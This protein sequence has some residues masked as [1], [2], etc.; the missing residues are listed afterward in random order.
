MNSCLYECEVF[1]RRLRPKSHEF[2]YRVFYFYLDLGELDE[3]ARRLKFFRVNSPAA[4]SLRDGDHFQYAADGSG[5]PAPQDQAPRPMA[6]NVREFLRRAGA[7]LE[8]GGAIRMLCF[9][10]TFGYVFNPITIYWC[11]RADGAPHAA[12][13]E[14][15]NTFHELKPYLVPCA[16]GKGV[17][18]FEVRV[19]KE[20]YVSPFSPLDLEFHFRFH[21]PDGRLRVFIDDYDAAGKVLVS[22]LTGRRA[23]LSDARLAWLTLKYPL[24]TLRVIGLIHWQALKLWLKR[25][26][27]FLKEARPSDQRGV[28]RPHASLKKKP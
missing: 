4:Y 14:V 1:H 7:P 8:D 25:M 10:R 24:L 13:V 22:T 15:G 6:D 19:P 20:Y 12:V 26:P 17:A 18:D 21:L 23:E 28:F 5:Q 16:V 27:F 3:I 11:F 2:L 9:P